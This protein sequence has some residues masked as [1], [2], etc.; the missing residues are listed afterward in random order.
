MH[1][2]EHSQL[3]LDDFDKLYSRVTRKKKKKQKK[4]HNNY[5]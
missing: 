4:I 1:I 3:I 5:W 2:K